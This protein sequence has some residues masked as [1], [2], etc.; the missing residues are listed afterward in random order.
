MSIYLFNTKITKC[1]YTGSHAT[2]LYQQQNEISIRLTPISK[3][4][5]FMRSHKVHIITV[6]TQQQ[7][8]SKNSGF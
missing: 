8:L 3:T 5:K 6:Q 2:S 4:T 1:Q 7:I